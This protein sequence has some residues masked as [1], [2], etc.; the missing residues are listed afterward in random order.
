VVLSFLSDKNIIQIACGQNHLIALSDT[1]LVY[2]CTCTLL[3]PLAAC[4]GLTS[5]HRSRVPRSTC[6]QGEWTIMAPWGTARSC[7][8]SRR[9]PSR[10][11]TRS[12][13]RRWSATNAAPLCWK[14][15]GPL[16]CF[17]TAARTAVSPHLTM[18]LACLTYRR[19][20]SVMAGMKGVA[21]ED[22][23]AIRSYAYYSPKERI[24]PSLHMAYQCHQSRSSSLP[25]RHSSDVLTV[26]ST[27]PSVQVTRAKRQACWAG[28]SGRVP[29][30]PSWGYGLPQP[31]SIAALRVRS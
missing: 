9:W 2:T 5:R 21:T 22:V 29:T 1:G 26:S 7:S 10:P 4:L 15:S 19:S 14:T 27:L 20:L 30:R 31:S 8:R 23:K 28:S 12:S 25:C 16:N 11:S 3:L 6:L 13:C 18:W 17:G 24:M